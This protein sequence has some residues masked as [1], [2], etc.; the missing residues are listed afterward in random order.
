MALTEWQAKELL[1]EIGRRVWTRNYVA[2]NEGNFSY[3][4]DDDRVL[5]TPTGQSKG[6]M[7]V[8][9]IVTVDMSGKKISGE[10]KPTSEVKV[11]LEIYQQR[12]DI[13]SVIHAHPPYATAFAVMKRP[14][15][16]CVLPEVEVFLG[17]IPIVEYATIG[18]RD[19]ADAVKP[20]LGEFSSFLLANHGALTIGKDIEDAYYKMEIVEEYCRVLH[21]TRTLDGY[22]Q[23]N[24]EKLSEL[25]QLKERL[26]IPDRRL[27]PGYT[28]SCSKESPGPD[29]KPENKIP[30]RNEIEKIV[31]QLLKEKGMI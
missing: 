29:Y 7:K 28:L 24:E 10:K 12:E 26:G 17:E 4:I 8:E 6:F 22:T 11:H 13:K 9:D 23:I 16:Q 30:E 25:L 31:R 18:S 21:Y 14:L 15:P 5:T 2:S 3:R 19:L 27:K 1:C 20:F